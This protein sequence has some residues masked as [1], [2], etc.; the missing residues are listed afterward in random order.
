MKI[1]LIEV[2]P[3]VKSKCRKKE[4]GKDGRKIEIGHNLEISPISKV[5]RSIEMITAPSVELFSR[6]VLILE[7]WRRQSIFIQCLFSFYSNFPVFFFFIFHLR[8]LEITIL[9]SMFCHIPDIHIHIHKKYIKIK[10]IL[11]HSYMRKILNK[12]PFFELYS[13]QHI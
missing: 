8:Y 1:R 2:L 4:W 11:Y 9:I 13:W 5:R 12:K 6:Y 10:H 3:F 7:R